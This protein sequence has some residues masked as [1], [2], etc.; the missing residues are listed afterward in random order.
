[1]LDK[2]EDGGNG[3]LM[4]EDR[5]AFPFVVEYNYYIV[6]GQSK[7]QIQ[8]TPLQYVLM[9]VTIVDAGKIKISY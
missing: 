3:G 1:M 2:R 5:E 4:L 9:F 7:L 8:D 6:Y